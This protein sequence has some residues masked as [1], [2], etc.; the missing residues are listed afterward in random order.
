MK[1]FSCD[2]CGAVAFFENHQC[3][4]C[5]STLAFI[6]EL[7]EVG[8]ISWDGAVWR[9]ARSGA[10]HAGYQLCS[11]AGATGVCNEVVPADSAEALCRWC[12]F[13]DTIPDLSV[14]GN[15]E[16]W[17]KL[18]GAQR[19]LL[20]GLTQLQL[21]PVSKRVDPNRGLIFSFLAATAQK[22]VLTGHEDGAITLNIAEADDAERERRREQMGEEY[23]TLLGH[24][25]HEVGHYY[26][27]RLIADTGRHEEFRAVFG[28]ERADYEMALKTHYAQGAP[29]DWESRFVSEY[30]STHA[31]ED[32]AETWAH[33]LHM[34]A[35]LETASSCGL[36]LR[37][38]H[39]QQPGVERRDVPSEQGTGDFE[40]LIQA[41]KAVTIAL[42]SLN[43]SI[44]QNDAYPFA[45]ANPVI[46]K[47]EFIHNTIRSGGQAR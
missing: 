36:S 6:P 32:W 25:R 13:T 23:R 38:R 42:N 21:N 8:A 19:R 28:D 17:R 39:Q 27:D 7:L 5:G 41:W 20:Y 30:A 9:S 40:S 47:L 26:W 12:Q 10:H 34:T 35:V 31:W 44:G 1:T 15:Q 46:Q 2:A 3:L 43:R 33:Y 37:P 4:S 22:N 18:N 29:P 24:F 14:P 11:N 16:R 45:L